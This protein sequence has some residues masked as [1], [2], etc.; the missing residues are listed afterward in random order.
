MSQPWSAIPT[1]E[2]QPLAPLTALEPAQR[3]ELVTAAWA[4]RVA[5]QA[6]SGGGLNVVGE[7]LKGQGTFYEMNHYPDDDVY[8]ARS[9]AQY[10]YHAHREE[11]HGHFHTFVRRA[12]MPETLNPAAGFKR[13]EPCPQGDDALAHLIC[14]SMDADGNPKGLFAANRWVT[15]ESWYSAPDTIALLDQFSIDHARPNLAVN[16]WLTQFMR[17]YRPHIEQLLQHRDQV[18]D[19]WQQRYPDDDV[20]E[21]RR[22]E[23]TGYM[24]IDAPSWSTEIEHCGAPA[25]AN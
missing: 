8:D 24:P 17:L 12:G 16:Q 1:I 7:I 21:D 5:N 14:I 19:A 18:V 4:M 15:D 22:L 3:R 25:T 11:E 6:L 13:S 9:H 20:L 2:I 23:I 10:Y